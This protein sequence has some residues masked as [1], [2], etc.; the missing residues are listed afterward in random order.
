MSTALKPIF[1][2]LDGLFNSCDIDYSLLKEQVL[3]ESW[4]KDYSNQRIVNSFLFNYIKIQD[5]LGASLFRKLLFSLREINNENLPMI[6]ML[7]LL[8]KLEI[9]PSILMWDKLREIRN[10]IA[11]EYPL[12]IE[13]RLENIA[14]ALSGFNQLKDLY[15]NIKQYAQLKQVM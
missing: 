8:E 4:L 15:A 13:E 6:D 3:N 5:K 14:L 12:E 11:H 2:S 7:N 10:A 1:E 9:I